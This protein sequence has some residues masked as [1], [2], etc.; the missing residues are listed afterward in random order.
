MAELDQEFNAA[1]VP[2]DDRSFDPIPAGDYQ[3]QVVESEIKPTK[4]GSG[5]QLVLTLE[6]IDGP[7]QN[8]KVWD[9]MNI[10]NENADAQRIAQRA[11]ADLCL[12]IGIANLKNSEQLHFKPFVGRVTIKADK[13]GQYGPQNAIRYKPRGGT[14]PAGK[15]QPQPGLANQQPTER[16]SGAQ[17]AERPTAGTAQTAPGA[18]PWKKTA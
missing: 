6:V 11:L 3:M 7:H 2:E 8:R 5:D 18:R 17:T 1:D 16:R 4:S 15:A 13:S 12:A 10:R 9:R 14:V